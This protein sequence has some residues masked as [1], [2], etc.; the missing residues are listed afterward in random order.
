MSVYGELLPFDTIS[1]VT[2]EEEKPQL[3][4]WTYYERGKLRRAAK[5]IFASKNKRLGTLLDDCRSYANQPLEPVV[6]VE[7]IDAGDELGVFVPKNIKEIAASIAPGACIIEE[8]AFKLSSQI[9][10]LLR[11][12]EVVA[13][14]EIAN[15]DQSLSA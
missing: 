8:P 3:S 11:P 5:A 10:E 12:D 4:R 14:R 13:L 6:V 7:K 15:T 2:R 1:D 9:G